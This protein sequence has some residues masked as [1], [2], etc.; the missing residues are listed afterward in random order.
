MAGDIEQPFTFNFQVESAISDSISFGRFEKESLS[1][2]RRSS[3]SH[4]RYLEEVEKFSKPGSVNEKKAYFEAHFKKKGG[5]LGQNSAES[6]TIENDVS[7]QVNQE[8]DVEIISMENHDGHF[9]DSSVSSQDH[10][11]HLVTKF[12]DMPKHGMSAPNPK[13]EIS[14]SSVNAQINKQD[15]TGE[16]KFSTFV[17]DEPEVELKQ[18]ANSHGMSENMQSEAMEAVPKTELTKKAGNNCSGSQQTLTPKM[19]SRRETKASFRSQ[20]NISQS[21]RNVSGDVLKSNKSK[22]EPSHTTYTEAHPSKTVISRAN[23]VRQTPKPKL[24]DSKVLKGRTVLESRSGEKVRTSGISHSSPSKLES[25]SYLKTATRPSRTV[26]SAMEDTGKSASASNRST[27]L[28]ERRKQG[29][30]DSEMKKLQKNVD[31]RSKPIP[32]SYGAVRPE[33]DGKKAVL[34]GSKIRNTLRKST[35]AASSSH[36]Q[37]GKDTVSSASEASYTSKNMSYHAAVHGEASGNSSSSSAN[38]ECLQEAV[39]EIE[40]KRRK[41]QAKEKEPNVQKSRISE[42][43]KTMSKQGIEGRQKVGVRRSMNLVGRSRDIKGV[44]GSGMG[45]FAVGV[46]S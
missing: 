23:A 8:A 43:H 18:D 28:S 26:N 34:S 45:R 10:G 46:T 42:N 35:A 41:D 16:N 38:Q 21:R 2:E 32:S 19:I 27:G 31:I 14:F 24:E 13:F 40:N 7:E 44:A 17:S 3:F 1:W 33:L 15:D 4:N 39:S 5:L 22:G 36:S 11:D 37:L 25:R 30:A 9:D 20:A 29:K 12:E 6:H